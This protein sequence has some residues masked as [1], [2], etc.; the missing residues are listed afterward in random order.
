MG[1]DRTDRIGS[2]VDCPAAL[3]IFVRNLDHLSSPSC[4]THIHH[5]TITHRAK[6]H[7]VFYNVRRHRPHLAHRPVLP[8]LRDSVNAGT[9]GKIQGEIANNILYPDSASTLFALPSR[10]LIVYIPRW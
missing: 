5:T 10:Q 3:H 8:N 7:T 4:G 9:T 1:F 2:Y 6:L